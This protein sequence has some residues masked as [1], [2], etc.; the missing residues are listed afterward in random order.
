MCTTRHHFNLVGLKAGKRLLTPCFSPQS[1]RTAARSSYAI[2]CYRPSSETG[3]NLISTNQAKHVHH[4]PPLQSG[5]LKSWQTSSHTLFFAA[6]ASH[7]SP[8]LLRYHL[9][10][11]F[12]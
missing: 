7:G 12:L 3:Q 10:S 2:I 6:I 4:T 1:H 5:R 11:P 9:L 8:I